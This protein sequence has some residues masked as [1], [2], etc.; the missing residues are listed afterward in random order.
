[1]NYRISRAGIAYVSSIF[2]SKFKPVPLFANL[3]ITR[4]CNLKCSFCGVIK[5]Q[6]P[7]ELSLEEWKECSDILYSMGNRLIS[8]TGG[9]PLLR[10]DIAD[11]IKHLSKKPVLSSMITNGTLLTEDKLKEIAKAGIMNIGLSTQSLIPDSQIKAQRTELFD[12]LLEYKKKYGIEISALITITNE[13]YKE[14]PQMA[15]YLSDHGIRISPNMVTSG[16]EDFWRFRNDAS[17]LLFDNKTLPELIKT[18]KYLIALKRK[19]KITYSEDYLWKL[20]QQSRGDYWWPCEAGKSYL[21]INSDGKVMVCQDLP[22]T[23]IHYRDLNK[24]YPLKTPSCSGCLWP[25][26]YEEHYKKNNTLKYMRD[27]FKLLI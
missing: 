21:S 10:P 15:K 25:C 19:G 2:K 6:S 27:L 22:P 1:M 26:Y 23:N 12:L 20:I 18:I 5:H 13:N 17:H 4:R 3:F 11:F 7:K 8:I 14:V 16:K 24:N 9:E